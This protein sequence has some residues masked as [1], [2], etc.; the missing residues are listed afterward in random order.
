MTCVGVVLCLEFGNDF[1][2]IHFAT[3]FGNEAKDALLIVSKFIL[4]ERLCEG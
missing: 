3:T 1:G 2:E 4:L